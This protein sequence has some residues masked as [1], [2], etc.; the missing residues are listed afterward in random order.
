[1]EIVVNGDYFKNF[2]FSDDPDKNI[3]M[4]SAYLRE[5]DLVQE[6]D[7]LD[8]QYS[9]WVL[10]SCCPDYDGDVTMEEANAWADRMREI[11]KELASLLDGTGITKEEY[12]A[13]K[14]SLF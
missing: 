2:V 11:E 3:I 12:E 1:M 9:N 13:A 14:K 4:G 8:S 5:Y 6:Y 10:D 7:L